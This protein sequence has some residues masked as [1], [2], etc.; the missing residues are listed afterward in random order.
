MPSNHQHIISLIPKNTIGM[1]KILFLLLFITT[2]SLAHAQHLSA[3]NFQ[4]SRNIDKAKMMI[5]QYLSNPK[6]ASVAD[7]WYYKGKIYYQLSKQEPSACMD[8]AMDAFN[9]FKKYQDL[10]PKNTFMHATQNMELFDM[11]N[12]YFEI[13]E[14]TFIKRNYKG[15]LNDF[16]K[17]ALIAGYI[18]DKNF[19]YNGFKFPPLDTLLVTDLAVTARAANDDSDAIM[20]YKMLTNADLKDSDYI[21]NYKYVVNY[22]K[23]NS[24]TADFKTTLAKGKEFYPNDPYWAAIDYPKADAKPATDSIST[25]AELNLAME[26]SFYNKALDFKEAVK[27]AK[28]WETADFQKRKGLKDSSDAAMNEVINYGEVSVSQYETITDRNEKDQANYVEA[29]SLLKKMFSTRHDAANATRYA[30]KLKPTDIVKPAGT[31]TSAPPVE[32]T[33][34]ADTKPVVVEPA[35]V[36]S[37]DDLSMAQSLYKK[38]LDYKDSVRKAKGWETADFQ[39]RK[40]LKDI[41]DA[42]ITSAIPYGEAAAKSHETDGDKTTYSQCL[43]LLKDLYTAQ[44]N[45]TKAAEYGDK[46]NALNGGTASTTVTTVT[47]EKVVTTP[48]VKPVVAIPAPAPSGSDLSI[49]QSFYK[50]ALDYKDS[51]KKAKG[52]ETTDFQNRKRLK[53]IS[54]AAITSAIPYGEAAAKSHETDG[55]KTTYSQSLSLLKDLYTAQ[56]NSI[57]AAEYSDKLNALNGVQTTSTTTTVTTDNVIAAPVATTTT[58]DAKPSVNLS[59]AQ[60]LYQQSLD[61]KEAVKQAKG[62]ETADFQKR[63]KLKD[64]SD[65]AIT[66]A[67]VY[68]EAAAKGYEA[69]TGLSG[70]DKS[71]YLKSLSLLQDLYTAKHDDV[72]AAEYGAK[73]RAAL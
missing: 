66:Q 10:D 39:N 56:H 68:G 19:S 52:W 48:V 58:I 34:T 33:I 25:A 67:I 12:G 45:S 18:K 54:D 47:T 28:G 22:D 71:N 51:V 44:H 27:Q 17:A 50:R 2:A 14:K 20:Y 31:I 11:Y 4:I 36:V 13:G 38:A 35:P 24:D 46:L 41:S 65:A 72:K 53:D 15:A 23:N 16:Q 5:D 59:T 62:W 64:S 6:K 42:A 7:G 69:I 9:A 70:T 26:T 55:D 57:K 43:S 61:F 73:L 21:D 37:G 1:K 8:C 32:K 49:A 30:A 3:I 63:K 40:R 29:V 60:S